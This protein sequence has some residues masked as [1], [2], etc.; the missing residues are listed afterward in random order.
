MF[1]LEPQP[2][3]IRVLLGTV[4]LK[5]FQL[6]FYLFSGFQ[7]SCFHC[8]CGQWILSAIAMLKVWA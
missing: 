7:N 8:D 4:A 2:G 6:F 1:F 3:Q 5:I